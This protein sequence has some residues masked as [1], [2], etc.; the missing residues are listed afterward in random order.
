MTLAAEV[1]S[2]SECAHPLRFLL[3]Q[4]T[5]TGCP[6]QL[7]MSFSPK[8]KEDLKTHLKFCGCVTLFWE[9]VWPEGLGREELSFSIL[10]ILRFSNRN[11]RRWGDEG[12]W[13]AELGS[14]TAWWGPTLLA[15]P[16][17]LL[18][19]G[20]WN[21]HANFQCTVSLSQ[22]SEVGRLEAN[23]LPATSLLQSLVNRGFWSVCCSFL[24][25]WGQ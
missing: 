6:F 5:D 9:Q 3:Y 13:K 1:A 10:E 7:I 12:I 2:N 23:P 24:P 18:N 15:N 25:I 21:C 19:L 22:W 14:L 4:L 16:Q 11:R 20:F 8:W 17:M